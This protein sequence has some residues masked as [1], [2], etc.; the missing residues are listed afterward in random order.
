MNFGNKE[1]EQV[2]AS[3]GKLAARMGAGVATAC[4]MAFAVPA[5]A[6]AA[7]R[8]SAGISAILP[9]MDEFIPML[10]AFIILLLIL[11]KFGWPMFDAVLQKREDT[12][13]EAIEKSEAARIES[14]RVLAE[15]Q[16]KLAEAR[17][18]SQAIV[19]EAK[20]RAEAQ[21]AQAVATAQAEAEAIIAKAREAIESEKKA[22]ISEL[23]GSVADLTVAVTARVIGEDFSDEDH[24]KL[25]E[26]S[27]AEV[28]NL[29]A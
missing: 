27:I 3:K 4:G 12:V 16:E 25:I 26:R 19:A 1:V 24:R 2:K 11:G 17:A 9:Q 20:Q 13:R 8:E 22:A 7:E 14:E 6:F 15:Y 23:Q 18:E 21:S 5:M 10:I 28:G 29:N